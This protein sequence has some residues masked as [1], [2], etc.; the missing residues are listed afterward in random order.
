V[1]R[2]V[3]RSLR[4]AALPAPGGLISVSDALPEELTP[5]VTAGEPWRSREAVFQRVAASVKADPGQ[6]ARLLHMWLESE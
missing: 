5:S 3:T 4:T 1:I 6:S 2:P